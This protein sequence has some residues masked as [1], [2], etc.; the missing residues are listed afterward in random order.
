MK[1]AIISDTHDNMPRFKKAVDWISKNGIDAIIHCGDI[2]TPESMREGL[3]SFSGNVW[4]CLGNNDIDYQYKIEDSSNIKVFEKVGEIKVGGKK[5][6]FVHYPEKARIL[7]ASLKYDVVFYGHS[8][9]PWEENVGT[10]RLVNPGTCGGIFYKAT[11]A[12]YNT[13]TDA[14]ELKIIDLL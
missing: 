10:C 8:H 5:I 13:E 7:A 9:R 3:G 4:A 1:I 2:C 12:V 6:A 14:L 11:F